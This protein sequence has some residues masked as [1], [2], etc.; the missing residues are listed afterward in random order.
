[1]LGPE[2]LGDEFTIDGFAARLARRSAPIKALLLDQSVVAG[3][4]NIYADESLFHAR[5]HPARAG[6]SLNVEEITRLHSAVRD[7]LRAGIARRGSTLGG[8]NLQNYLRPG[9]LPGDF[10]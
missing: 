8:S 10:Q 2:P 5:I 7:V 1:K 4:G 9:G 6:G 3:V